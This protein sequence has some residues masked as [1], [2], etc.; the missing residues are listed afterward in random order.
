VPIQPGIDVGRV[1][2]FAITVEKP[3]GT[4]VPDLKRRVVVAPRG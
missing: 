2:L 1:T 3:G 4:W